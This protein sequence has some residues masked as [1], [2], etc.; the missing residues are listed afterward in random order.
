MTIKRAGITKIQPKTETKNDTEFS[1]EL[2]DK[3]QR[4]SKSEV[5]GISAEQSYD[6]GI[7]PGE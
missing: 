3:T 6:Y 4:T 7:Y 1:R 5:K 2:A